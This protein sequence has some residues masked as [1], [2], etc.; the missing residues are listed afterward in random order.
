[1]TSVEE[2]RTDDR[3]DGKV[4]RNGVQVTGSVCRGPMLDVADLPV[5]DLADQVYTCLLEASRKMDIRKWT[6]P[7]TFAA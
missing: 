2:A 5:F 3:E 7:E 1:M 4:A 6:I